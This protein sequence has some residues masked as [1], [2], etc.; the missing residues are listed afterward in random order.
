PARQKGS[1]RGYYKHQLMDNPLE[2]PGDMDLTTHIHFDTLISM[3]EKHGFEFVTKFRQDEFLLAAGI[4]TFLQDNFDSNPFSE[5]SKQNRAIRSL[6]MDGGM[7]SAFHVLIQQKN[8]E[9][10]W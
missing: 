4:L 2:H 7:S 1:L 8:V 3:G 10:K 6:I 5:I 9:I